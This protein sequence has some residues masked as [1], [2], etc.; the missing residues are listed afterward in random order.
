[1]LNSRITNTPWTSSTNANA[2]T[3]HY[4]DA[5][6]A[7]GWSN[8][9]RAHPHIDKQTRNGTYGPKGRDATSTRANHRVWS[10]DRYEQTGG[11]SSNTRDRGPTPFQ[12]GRLGVCTRRTRETVREIRTWTRSTPFFTARAKIR[13]QDRNVSRRLIRWARLPLTKGP[14]AT[15]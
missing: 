13:R 7:R 2:Y 1:M 11:G 5:N 10:G 14:R 6:W 12:R 15:H 8:H 9:S 4:N 3:T